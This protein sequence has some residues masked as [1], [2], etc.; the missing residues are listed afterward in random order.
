M[1]FSFLLREMTHL[2]YY[3]PIIKEGNTRGIKSNFYITPSGKYNCPT[4]HGDF[5]EKIM[6]EH[7]IGTLEEGDLQ[8]VGGFW[9]ANESSGLDITKR[10]ASRKNAK[11]I[12]TTYQTDFTQCYPEYSAIADYIMMPSENIAQYYNLEGEKN[13]YVGIPKYDVQLDSS[14]VLE[15]YGLDPNKKKVLLMW[16]KS[17]DLAKFPIDII[18]N[19]QQLGW[20]VVVK[21]RG[22]DPIS[23]NTADYLLSGGHKYFYDGWFPHTSQELLKVSDLVVNCGSTTIEECVMYEVP[24]INFDIK[25]AVRH[26]KK[27]KHRV[28]HDYLYNYKFCVNIPALNKNFNTATLSA[29]IQSLLQLD[30]K[31]E[32]KKCKQDWLYGHKNTCKNLLDMIL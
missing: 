21:A 6:K 4:I 11:V 29:M 7:D 19:F 16:P 26:G 15:K 10:I 30:L 12:I 24:L 31:S 28:T 3:I 27:Q 8:S 9:F 32:F 17:R 2:R 18:S 13:I 1:M 25:P 22:K 20:Q 23:K 14:K 5:L